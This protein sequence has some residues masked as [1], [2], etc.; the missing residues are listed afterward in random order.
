MSDQETEL[1]RHLE[2]HVRALADRIGERNVARPAA[3]E[4]AARY[5]EGA[6]EELGH[7]VERQ[8]VEPHGVR[9]LGVELAGR[10][11][12]DEIVLAGA[13]YDSVFGSP[14]ADDNA[15][16][17]AAVLEIARLLEGSRLARTVRLVLFVNEEPPFFLTEAMGSRHY[18]A[19]SRERDER[20]VA[21]L[22]LETL[23]YYSDR[24]GSQRYPFPFGLLYPS[25]ADFVGFVSN[26]GSRSLLRRCVGSFR[27]TT[28]FPSEGLAAPAW[29]PGVSWSDHSSFWEQGYP[30]VMVTDTALYRYPAYHTAADTPDRVDFD[31]LAR[32]VAGLARVVVDLAGDDELAR[33]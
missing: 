3:L 10:S 12:A 14:G 32:V 26:I 6:F 18:A 31:R 30:A 21:M 11:L 8:V 7:A 33:R 2:T 25:R 19:R 4:A 29:I 1:R 16:G 28:A 13:H 23:G 17:T 24:E 27:R 5:L 22:S 20:I 15:T 9:N